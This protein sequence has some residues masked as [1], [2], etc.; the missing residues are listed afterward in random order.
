MQNPASLPTVCQRLWKAEH[1]TR[2]YSCLGPYT[3]RDKCLVS[4]ISVF[5]PFDLEPKKDPNAST[6]Q[7]SIQP[8]QITTC[9][10]LWTLHLYLLGTLNGQDC[11]HRRWPVCKEPK[12]NQSRACASQHILVPWWINTLCRVFHGWPIK[13]VKDWGTGRRHVALLWSLLKGR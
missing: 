1:C 10:R 11:M 5:Q 8:Q 13:M 6:T 3:F 4:R 7:Y 2:C 9:H 12:C